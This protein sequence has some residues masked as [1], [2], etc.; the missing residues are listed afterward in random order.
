MGELIKMTRKDF[1]LIADVLKAHG[2]SP[3]NRLVVQE[4]AVSFAQK[5]TETNPRFDQKRF[6]EACTK[7]A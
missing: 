6:V 3:M 1:Q 4:L 5:L 2:T 7:K